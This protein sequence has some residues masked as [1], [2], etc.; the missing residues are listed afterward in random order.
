[1][2]GGRNGLHLH[3]SWYKVQIKVT[4]FLKDL[5]SV[6]SVTSWGIGPQTHLNRDQSHPGRGLSLM[7]ASE[8]K[9]TY[10]QKYPWKSFKHPCW[11]LPTPRPPFP[12]FSIGT[13]GCF[14]SQ[15]S[16]WSGQVASGGH[17]KL[18]YSLVLCSRVSGHDKHWE[19]RLALGTAQSQLW[20]HTVLTALMA[21]SISH[22]YPSSRS[23][24]RPAPI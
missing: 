4:P 9:F 5:T 7:L 8:K 22:Q 1:M 20:G 15:V 14:F 21:G 3:S 10:R 16:D 17:V 12:C 6:S 23:C 18:N 11:H 13:N 2:G 19:L 24:F